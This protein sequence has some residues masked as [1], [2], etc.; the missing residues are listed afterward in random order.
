ME[1]KLLDY[2]TLLHSTRQYQEK[3]ENDV[4]QFLSRIQNG[5]PPSTLQTE[6]SC[7]CEVKYLLKKETHNKNE[8]N[9]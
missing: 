5:G 9:H 7:F 2:L 3:S 4:I 8:E 6:F 1:S